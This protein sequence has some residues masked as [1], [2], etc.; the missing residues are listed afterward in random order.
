MFCGACAVSDRKDTK[1]LKAIHNASSFPHYF[2]FTTEIAAYAFNDARL[3]E[4]FDVAFN[5]S[6]IH[7]KFFRNGFHADTGIL[8]HR[9][10]N[11]L[12]TAIFLLLYRL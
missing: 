3:S 5:S 12:P 2:P 8:M 9:T 11:C 10:D 7:A 4:F 1:L 6:F